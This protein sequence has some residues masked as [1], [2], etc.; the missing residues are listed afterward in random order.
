M[1]LTSVF[2]VRFLVVACLCLALAGPASARVLVLGDSLSAAYGIPAQSGWVRLLEERLQ[3]VGPE[4]EVVNASISGDTSRG[5]LARLPAALARHQPDVVIIELGGNDGLRGL[6]LRRLR[7]NLEQM[8]ELS[9]QA[10]ALPLLVGIKLPANYGRTFAERFHAV[11]EEVATTQGV[12]LV[13]FLLEG[14]A[15]DP[16]LMQA[17]GIHPTADAQ[18]IMLE[19]VWP[20]LAPLLDRTPAATPAGSVGLLERELLPR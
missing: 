5:G 18:P 10:G 2:N 20:V 17:D 12:P 1:T 11:F 3:T 14:V 9:R 16:S 19:N 15:L 4:L 7:G 8:I 13:P 6:S